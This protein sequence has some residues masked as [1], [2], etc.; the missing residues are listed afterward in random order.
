MRPRMT[1][2]PANPQTKT[3]LTPGSA[4]LFTATEGVHHST[5]GELLL[6][7]IRYCFIMG[8]TN[9]QNQWQL[10]FLCQCHLSPEP[11]PLLFPLCRIR[12]QH[13]VESGFSQCHKFLTRKLILQGL[14]KPVQVILLMLS[15]KVRVQSKSIIEWPLT[16]EHRQLFTL[17]TLYAGNQ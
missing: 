5:A 17:R 8:A 14:L 11:E 3:Q 4:L 1:H 7:Q 9:M 6:T 16:T 10:I 12:R 2:C 15:D 13:P